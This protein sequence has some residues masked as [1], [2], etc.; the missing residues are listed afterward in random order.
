MECFV[1]S[2]M[3]AKQFEIEYSQVPASW[4]KNTLQTFFD[5]YRGDTVYIAEYYR[6]EVKKETVHFYQGL[7]GDE[8]KVS[9]LEFKDKDYL[10]ELEA[11]GYTEV[12]KKQVKR[13]RVHKYIMSGGGILEDCGYIAGK[14]IP[15]I[16]TYGKRSFIDNVERASGFVR[17]CKDSGRLQNV[18]ASKVAEIAS[19]SSVKKPIYLPEQIQGHE[20]RWAN[21]AVQDY[22][23][24]LINL[25]YDANGQ[26]LPPGPV[27]YTQS[28]D[29]PP[30]IAALLQYSGDRLNDLMGNA[31]QG[32]KLQSN[33]S[34]IAVELI[35]AQI[36]VQTAGYMSNLAIA[37]SWCAK[38]WLEIIKEIYIEEGRI[39]KGENDGGKTEQIKLKK[40]VINANG[41]VEIINDFSKLKA[42]DV[43]INI[44]A[45]S[46][47][48]RA[49]TEKGLIGL[50]GNIQD[51]A[52]QSIVGNMILANSEG[53]GMSE[54][55]PYFR[56]Q[57]IQQGAIEPSQEELHLWRQ[58]ANWVP[59]GRCR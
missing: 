30:A 47:S 55:R 50:M 38:V 22:A 28:P 31:D 23:Y 45:S 3:D 44:G 43:E 52:T 57:L 49:A 39:L 5:W 54:L 19:G 12:R 8:I 36:S 59:D 26:T 27:G 35:Q 2:S 48:R 40:P 7:T 17:I 58:P 24:Q 34:G 21:D 46:E 33:L 4:P 13:Q 20:F 10:S 51:P 18:Q 1:V 32:E 25:A 16:I 37:E 9:A 53:E 6:V 29:L 11:Q 14:Y 15:I 56:K 42:M 41:E